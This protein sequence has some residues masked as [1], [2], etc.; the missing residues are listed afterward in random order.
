[1][2]KVSAWLETQRDATALSA[3]EEQVTGRRGYVRKALDQLTREG[4]ITEEP[5]PRKARLFTTRKQYREESDP[6]LQTLENDLAPPRPDLARGEVESAPATSPPPYRGQ[7][8][9]RGEVD[10]QKQHDLAPEEN[11]EEPGP[12]N[13]PDQD[14]PF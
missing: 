2:E 9:K 12:P 10:D 5:G 14:I 13:H 1:M 8:Q 6:L 7:E 11:D 4:Y 3:I